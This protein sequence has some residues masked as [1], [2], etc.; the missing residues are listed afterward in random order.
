MD[1][2]YLL[3]FQS[4]R[5]ALGPV[6]EEFVVLLSTGLLAVAFAAALLIY[7]LVDKRQGIYLLFSYSAGSLVNQTI[8]LRF[9]RYEG[10]EIPEGDEARTEWLF[11]CWQKLDD[12]VGEQLT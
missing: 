11:E 2:D 12:W 9:W 8:K 6:T 10:S 7:W 1:I 4:V 5:E 3:A